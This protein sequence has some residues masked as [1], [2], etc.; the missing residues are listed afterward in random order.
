MESSEQGINDKS[1]VT[2]SAEDD[3][4][5]RFGQWVY[6][7]RSSV[8]KPLDPVWREHTFRLKKSG[9]RGATGRSMFMIL[10]KDMVAVGGRPWPGNVSEGRARLTLNSAIEHEL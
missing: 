8:G 5:A 7:S 1:A 9:A 3:L 2:W 10:L 4:L 6:R